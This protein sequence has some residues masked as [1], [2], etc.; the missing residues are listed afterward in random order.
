M[1][2]TQRNCVRPAKSEAANILLILLQLKKRG[3]TIRVMSSHMSFTAEF[4]L[5]PS[6]PVAFNRTEFI[7][8]PY[9]T[10]HT[11]LEFL[12]LF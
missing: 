4:L 11:P 1:T 9:L 2:D 10:Q 7:I 8:N 12:F 3:R 5:C 6:V